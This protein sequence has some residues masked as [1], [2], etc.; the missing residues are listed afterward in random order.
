MQSMLL[1][2]TQVQDLRPLRGW[3]KLA[4]ASRGGGLTFRGSPA[5][6][7]PKIAEIEDDVARA[8]AL[9]ALLVDLEDGKP[10]NPAAALPQD[11]WG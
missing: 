6:A 7:N 5:K 1:D 8:K 11:D 3:R 2:Y 9:V 4:N 10:V